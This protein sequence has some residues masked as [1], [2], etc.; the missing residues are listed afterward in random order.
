MKILITGSTGMVGSNIAALLK[1]DKDDDLLLPS[2]EELDL[3]NANNIKKYL[4]QKQPEIIIHAA[5]ESWWHT[6]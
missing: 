4:E 6:S 5:E 1:Q 3:C 2:H